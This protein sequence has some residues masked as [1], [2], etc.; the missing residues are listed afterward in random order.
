MDGVQA[1]ILYEMWT[2]RGGCCWYQPQVT[3][4][5]PGGVEIKQH[6][7]SFTSFLTKI[8]LML[9]EHG[10]ADEWPGCHCGGIEGIKKF[11]KET[12]LTSVIFNVNITVTVG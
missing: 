5:V 4:S 8:N 3:A 9:L 10:S 2:E 11:K 7:L 1:C 6:Y 12:K